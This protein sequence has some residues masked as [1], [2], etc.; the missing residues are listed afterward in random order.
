MGHPGNR[1]VSEAQHD[2][3]GVAGDGPSGWPG[4]V[5]Q[6]RD[7]KALGSTAGK[8]EVPAPTLA[9]ALEVIHDLLDETIPG[10]CEPNYEARAFGVLVLSKLFRIRDKSEAFEL[11]T[12][13]APKVA[14]DPQVHRVLD[15]GTARA[16][17]LEAYEQ[18]RVSEDVLPPGVLEA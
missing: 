18:G 6:R 12:K 11:L 3:R 16:R 5:K 4:R 10:S 8:P 14:A 9:R 2:R 1:Y 7:E 13:V 17:L 15:L